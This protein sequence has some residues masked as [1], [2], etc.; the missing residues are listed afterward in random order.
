MYSVSSAV[1]AD[2]GDYTC[3]ATN[4]RGQTEDSVTLNVSAKGFYHLYNFQHESWCIR[5]YIHDKTHLK[6]LRVGSN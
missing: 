5:I 6:K 4:S 1:E 2:A 3:V